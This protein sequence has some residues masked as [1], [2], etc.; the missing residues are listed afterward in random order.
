VATW[1]RQVISISLLG[2]AACSNSGTPK[3]SA[4]PSAPPTATTGPT[5]ATATTTPL[6]SFD[7][8]VPPPKLANT[9][10]N[11]KKILQSLLDYANWT[12][13]HRVEPSLAANFTAPSSAIDAGYRHDLGVLRDDKKRGYEVRD[14]ENAIRIV[15]ETTAAFTARVHEHIVSQNI[16]DPSG[17]VT[18]R[19]RMPSPTTAYQYVVVRVGERWY[20]AGVSRV[21]ED[22]HL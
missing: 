2:F 14:G 16:V 17:R 12:V 9:G 19:R 8:S 1:G 3:A 15:S 20:L 21:S 7:N 6:Y 22:V 18:S 5:S 10:S 4:P 11:H 13:A